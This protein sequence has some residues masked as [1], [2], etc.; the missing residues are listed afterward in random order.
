MAR[1][2]RLLNAIVAAALAL[3]VL[4]RSAHAQYSSCQ[5]WQRDFPDGLPGST[6]YVSI[7]LRGTSDS[8][9][10]RCDM[11]RRGGGWT[12]VFHH[13]YSDGR[14]LAQFGQVDANRDRPTARLYSIMSDVAKLKFDNGPYEFMMEWPGSQFTELQQ[15]MQPDIGPLDEV[16]LTQLVAI[17]TPYQDRGFIGLHV[18]DAFQ[19][20]FDGSLV[21]WAYAIMQNR[22]WGG[23]LYG[24]GAP[25]AQATLWVRAVTCHP[26]CATCFGPGPMQC[27]SCRNAEQTPVLGDC[28]SGALPQYGTCADILAANAS[29]TSGTYVIR[30]RESGEFFRVYCDMAFRGGGWTRVFRHDISNSA[31]LASTRQIDANVGDPEADLYSIMSQLPSLRNPNGPYEFRME[32]RV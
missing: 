30:A 3:L 21:G 10:V 25:V 19:A 13:D 16:S 17:N 26:N 14:G 2:A 31:E 24:P 23:G 15:W 4:P 9:F 8:V 11:T 20:A 6:E 22:P 5:D 28:T 32:V 18:S 7:R 1:P 27:R 29:A 12:R